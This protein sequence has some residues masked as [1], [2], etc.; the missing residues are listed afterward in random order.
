M[1]GS[2]ATGARALY[3][4]ESDIVEC[5]QALTPKQFR[6]TMPAGQRPGF[7]HDVYKTHYCG[8]AIYVKLQIADDRAWVVSFK[9]DEEP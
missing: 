4:D 1:T 3:L 2:A 9:K 7:F 6:K 5:V 8:F